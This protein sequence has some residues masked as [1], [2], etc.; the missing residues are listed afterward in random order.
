MLLMKQNVID[1]LTVVAL[2]EG[3]KAG[4]LPIIDIARPPSSLSAF[5]NSVKQTQQ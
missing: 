4:H 2:G 3:G 1:M 5:Q